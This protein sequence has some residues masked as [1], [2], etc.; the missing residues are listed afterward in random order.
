MPRILIVEDNRDIR[1]IIHE[2]LKRNG[3]EAVEAENGIHALEILKDD[4]HFDLIISDL[5]M[6]KMTGLELL[7]QL[8]ENYPGIPTI[9]LS[10]HRVP[11]WVDEAM[12]KGAVTYLTKP[13]TPEQLVSAVN[14]YLLQATS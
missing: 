3:Y 14:K 6:A 8:R 4:S 10:V 11:E 1:F 2:I 5:R 7:D 13:F 12:Q 9:I